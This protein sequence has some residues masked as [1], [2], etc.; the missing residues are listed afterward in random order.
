MGISSDAKTSEAT[1]ITATGITSTKS[2]VDEVAEKV[3]AVN[4]ELL[5]KMYTGM[6]NGMDVNQIRG[7]SEIFKNIN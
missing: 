4:L 6:I 5:D 3:K 2:I 1:T 7:Y